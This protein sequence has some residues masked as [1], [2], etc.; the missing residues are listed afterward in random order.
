MQKNSRLYEVKNEIFKTMGYVIILRREY[1][2]PFKN[3]PKAF[4][5]Y[6]SFEKLLTN[7]T[8]EYLNM[9]KSAEERKT[10]I[11]ELEWEEG[12]FLQRTSF[13]IK[14]SLIP[15]LKKEQVKREK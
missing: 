3:S 7:L 5:K 2:T 11:L 9:A 13:E 15:I 12:I 10:F 14:R 4:E 1:Y 8:N 6:L